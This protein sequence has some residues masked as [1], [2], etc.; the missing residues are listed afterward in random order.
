MLRSRVCFQLALL[1]VFISFATGTFAQ[2]L[3][4]SSFPV[5]STTSDTFYAGTVDSSG[6]VYLAGRNGSSLLVQKISANGATMV[7]RGIFPATPP[8]TYSF[9][10]EDIR[11]DST[12][13]AYVVGYSGPNFPTTTNAFLGS[14][15]SGDHAFVAVVNPAGTALTY[16]TYLAGTTSATDVANGVA[17]DSLSKIY[18]TGYTDSVT[19]PST[20]GVFQ[21]KNTSGQQ[22]AFVAKIDPTKSGS[23]S[24]V[25]STYLSGPTTASVEN[26]IA[27]DSSGDA[28]VTGNGGSD[29]PITKGA[30]SYDGE[31]LGQGGAYVT[32]LNPTA[33]A[34]LYS[35]YLGVGTGNGIAVDGSGVAY[36]TGTVNVEDFP[37]TTGAFQVTYPDG[38]ASE[39]NA[40]GSALVYSTYLS[41]AQELT[42]PTG[43]AIEPGCTSP[44]SAFI[45]GYTGEDDL[46]LTDP[47]QDFNASYVTINGTPET[48]ND[49]FVT[50]LNATGT[51]AV[52][53]TYV[54][55]SAD[56]STQNTAH[57]PSIAVNST[58]D[59]YVVGETSSPDFPVTLTATTLRNTFALE[60]APAS[61]VTAVAYPLTLAF[62]T[63]QPTGVASTPLV[64]NLRNMGSS[65]MTITGIT[66]TPAAY[67]ETNTCGTTLAA[68][69]ECPISVTFKPTTAA[70]TPGTLTIVQGGLSTIVTL[71]GTGVGQGFLTLNPTSLTFASQSVDFASPFQT[72]TVGNSA[73]TSLTLSNPPFTFSSSPSNAFAQTNNCPTS[74]ATNATCTVNIAFLPTENG[75]FTGDMFVSSNTNGLATPTFV[76]LSGNGVVGAPALTLSSA[77]LVFNPQVIGVTAP[78]QSVTVTNTGNVPV[79]IFGVSIT[80]AAFTDYT[81]SGCVQTLNP[82]GECFARISFVPTATGARAATIT[83]ADSTTAGTHTFT[84]T[85]TG[86]APSLTLAFDPPALTFANL[87]VGA[88][89][90]PAL[91]V[92]VTNTGN[93]PVPIDRVFTTGD[94]RVSST[95]CVSAGLRV[96]S[97]CNINV[98]FTPTA[99]GARSG[100]IVIEDT[101][102]GNPQKVTLTGTGLADAAAAIAT[103]D[104]LNLGTQAVGTTSANASTVIL[105]NTG[106]DPFDASN[107]TITGTNASDFQVFAPGSNCTGNVV[108]PGRNCQTQVTFTPTATGTRNGTLTFTNAAGTQTVS[109]TGT[110][111]AA[112]FALVVSP[113][114]LTYQP[115]QK[116]V[117]SPNQNVWLINTGSAA[118]TVSAIVSGSTDYSES[119]CLGTVIQPDTA[120]EMFVYLTPTVTTTDNSTLKVTSNAAGSP[121][122]ITLNGSGAT[123]AAAMEFSPGNLTFNSQVVATASTTQFVELLNNSASTVTGIPTIAASGANASDFAISGNSCTATLGSTSQCGFNVSFKPG[124]A[125]VR[126]AA[127]SITDSA[128]TQTLAL[129]GYG[130]TA[131]SSALL[132]ETV[133]Q[134]PSETIGFTSPNQAATFQNTGN[135]PIT[136]SSVVLGGTNPGDFAIS[137]GCPTTT[138]F[139]ALATCNTNVTFTPT[140]A[141]ARTATVT[142]TYTGATGSPAV[143]TLKGTGVT[144]S[145]GLVVGP[146][147][148]AFAP[149]VLT[150]QSPL[151]PSVLLTNTGTS[152]VTISSIVLGGTNPGDFAISDGCPISPSTLQQ[153]P[154]NNTCGVGVTF[155]PTAAGA[156]AATIKVTDSAPGS[157]TTINLSGTGV[158]ETKLLTVT[159]TTLVF[160]PQVTGTTSAQQNITVT[161]TGNFNVTF[162]NVTITTNYALANSCTGALP[163]G[164]SCIIGV[165]FTPTS[166][167]VKAG[168]VTITDNSTVGTGTQKVT[169]SGTGIA[170][171][172]DILLS[173]TTVV[174]DAQ[175][176]STLSS[177]QIVYYYNEGNTTS[178]IA[179]VVLSGTNPTDFSLSGSGCVA[180]A[181]VTALSYCTIRLT[182][183]PAAAG[184]RTATLTITDSD[185]GSPRKITVNG[186]GVSTNVP[187][188]GFLPTSLTFTTQNEGTTS[189][190]KNINLTN[191]GL[192][193]L[194]GLTIGIGG[195]DPG[196]FKQTNNC[197]STL[198]AGFSC[199]IAVTFAPT[200]IGTRTATVTATDN[201][202]GSPQSAALTGTG[203]A[204]A[205]PTVTLTPP[206]LTFPNVALNT[207][208]TKS[209]SVQNTGAAALNITS[210]TIA[211]AETTDFTLSPANTCSGSIAVSGTCTISVSFKPTTFEDQQA[212]VTIAD[213]AANSPQTIGITGNGAEPAV[214]LSPTS[215][216]F[217]S[218]PHNTTSAAQT[219]TVE[220]YGNATL[221]INSTIGV[222][223]PFVVS[224]NTCGTSL[225]AGSIC[226]ISVEFKPTVAGAAAG[227]LSIGDN[228]GDSPQIVALSGTGT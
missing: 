12:G 205:L 67:T 215:L 224:A 190:S 118:I 189:A 204:G 84:V 93:A 16:A 132:E 226:T 40:A 101:A 197:P 30:F 130:V 184:A 80:G 172:A 2:K 89:S 56:D 164:S 213:N 148:I 124:A 182:F 79:T 144:G 37:T 86:V 87:A 203:A 24:L 155:T 27:V 125:G 199:N 206:N 228:A 214:D 64:V 81:E 98:E 41:G 173:Q 176:V 140:A 120:C 46:T 109:L 15:T 195:A 58:G 100:S 209:V 62:P 225:A 167:G 85:G 36:V 143:I 168:T 202:A 35:A 9:Q 221:T 34:L 92:Q 71:T 113:T 207:N 138:P 14:V 201:A 57:S 38:F 145:Q 70:S 139:A 129:S 180:T 107:V 178:T 91:T 33:T 21:T 135:S 112:T 217:P 29:F 53:S 158:A 31:G 65:P 108:I 119:G 74:L 142:I 186:T 25:Y 131:S 166:T 123:G 5:G 82:G 111:V 210:I 48:G 196:D 223:G 165:T 136:I 3:A 227:T 61:G 99:A 26:A 177:P 194:T 105:D 141:G 78:S 133:L 134:F 187:E 160:G 7:Y 13:A 146:A 63:N 106:N 44:C 115:Q 73:T 42:T 32:K 161:N 156:R 193:N 218:T 216:T 1:I 69:G 18:V 76:T 54:G 200:A 110:G 147:S 185:P 50:E 68:G 95:G 219:I 6:N 4:W 222:T 171:T 220:N 150:T 17:V 104:S 192:G 157:P 52:Y 181:Q 77:G 137:S 191:N 88:T 75:P 153:G 127:V 152:P 179:S 22:I 47:I 117:Q 183:T 72:V 170:T 83:L 97:V 122:T 208:L 175:T 51:A 126:T 96:G 20:T 55:G 162:T 128:G 121:Q 60:V 90:T 49:V 23:A 11:V 154:L 43:I 8:F 39:L 19:F 94:F 211:G 45:V 28:Y 198:A 103:P 159:P 10:V 163:P 59:A 151:N 188:V 169:I 114:T 149:T 212:T 174:F 116:G 66:P 102:T